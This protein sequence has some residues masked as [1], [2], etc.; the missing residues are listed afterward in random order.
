MCREQQNCSNKTGHIGTKFVSNGSSKI[1]FLSLLRKNSSP[2]YILFWYHDFQAK[3][4][5]TCK[6][7]KMDS[8]S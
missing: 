1:N 3:C 8:I 5:K 6:K 4:K 7:L 2:F